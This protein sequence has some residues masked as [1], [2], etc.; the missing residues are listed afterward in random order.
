MDIY[1]P[2]ALKKVL[3]CFIFLHAGA[4]GDDPAWDLMPSSSCVGALEGRHR[5]SMTASS[6]SPFHGTIDGMSLVSQL[7]SM[8]S[9]QDER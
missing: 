2:L 8:N 3:F 1:I 4:Y 9:L 5:P 7:L 6:S